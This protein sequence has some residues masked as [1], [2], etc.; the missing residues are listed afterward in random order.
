MRVLIFGASGM[1]GHKLYQ[2]LQKDLDV[3]ATVR[4]DFDAVEK[5]EIFDR[6]SII[7]HVG[8]TDT[9]KV[10]RALD[11][12]MPNVVVNAVG[13]IKQVPEAVDAVTNLAVNSIFPQRLAQLGA[14]LNFRLITISTDCVFSGKTG[15]YSE[16]DEPDADDVYGMTKLLG[17]VATDNS[18]TL[19]TSIIGRELGT[20]HSIV[21][22]FLKNRG[23]K[24]KGYT[25]A[26]YSGFPTIVLSEII[27]KLIFDHPALSGIYHLSSEPITKFDLLKLLNEHYKANIEI[28]PFDDYRIDRSLDSSRFR[29]ETSFSPPAWHEMAAQMAADMTPYE[30]FHAK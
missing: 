24:I 22:W 11:I 2:R 5:Y 25:N 14:D 29:V 26:V 4:S 10:R 7:E 13:V 23:K 15:N 6:E 17:E 12:A 27:R 21:E 8:V 28:E 16:T 3:L 20:Q 30:K 18:V 9:A 19:R 1:L